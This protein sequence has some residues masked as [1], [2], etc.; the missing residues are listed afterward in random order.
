MSAER[1]NTPSEK[2]LGIR[3]TQL[4]EFLMTSGCKT[5]EAG[6]QAV[7]RLTEKFVCCFY[8]Q[9]FSPDEAI[10]ETRK[11]LVRNISNWVMRD[12]VVPCE[13]VVSAGSSSETKG[14]SGR[15]VA[16]LG[17]VVFESLVLVSSQQD[18]DGRTTIERGEKDDILWSAI[19]KLRGSE[20]ENILISGKQETDRRKSEYF[21]MRRTGDIQKNQFWDTENIDEIDSPDEESSGFT[22][23][24]VNKEYWQDFTAGWSD[25]NILPRINDDRVRE[26]NT[27]KLTNL[28]DRIDDGDLNPV[29]QSTNSEAAYMMREILVMISNHGHEWKDAKRDNSIDLHKYCRLIEDTQVVMSGLESRLIDEGMMQKDDE[30]TL[31]VSDVFKFLKFG[32]TPKTGVS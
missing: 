24:R 1:K 21:R 22:E 31:L 29:A 28:V 5:D 6:R 27:G 19:D 3:D 9:G 17:V 12:F 25:E 16:A 20:I 26:W 8:D 13:P 23:M 4:E 32:N 2:L 10:D 14:V 30:G 18:R 15:N 11:K 7:Y